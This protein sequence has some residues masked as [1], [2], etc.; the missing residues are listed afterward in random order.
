MTPV[1]M[2]NA[3][4]AGKIGSELD[5][6]LSNN[7]AYQQAKIEYGKQKQVKGVVDTVRNIYN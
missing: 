2:T 7:P 5:S 6:I 4:K 1:E 3:L